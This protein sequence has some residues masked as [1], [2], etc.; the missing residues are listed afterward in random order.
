MCSAGAVAVPGTQGWGVS[1]CPYPLLQRGAVPL[2]LSHLGRGRMIQLSPVTQKCCQ[3]LFR[4]CLH[5]L[6]KRATAGAFLVSAQN[7][8]CSLG[9]R[10]RPAFS[11]TWECRAQFWHPKASRFSTYCGEPSSF[12]SF[13]VC[14]TV[15]A[16]RSVTVPFLPDLECC[17][18]I[19]LSSLYFHP[20]NFFPPEYY[21]HK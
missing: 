2:P 8:C 16:E 6:N 3:V 18:T 1:V 19:A 13:A 4:W 17:H 9:Q 21:N 12:C 10:K 20:H 14:L 11:H 15:G 7:T 5:S